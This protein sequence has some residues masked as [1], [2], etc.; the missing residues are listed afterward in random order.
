MC[1]KELS[2]KYGQVVYLVQEINI[3]WSAKVVVEDQ[4]KTGIIEKGKGEKSVM[5]ISISSNNKQ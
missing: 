5:I 3:N 1:F 2:K 4:V